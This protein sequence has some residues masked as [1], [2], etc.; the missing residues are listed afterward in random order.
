MCALFIKT[1]VIPNVNDAIA[2]IQG[3]AR[4]GICAKS[5]ELCALSLC[6][7]QYDLGSRIAPLED[8]SER[9]RGPRREFLVLSPRSSGGHIYPLHD[10]T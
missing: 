2:C 6:S 1:K 8:R 5:E 10:S 4:F 3:N 9:T 7:K